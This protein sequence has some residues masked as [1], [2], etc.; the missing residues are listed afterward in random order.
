MSHDV[1]LIDAL[2]NVLW[3]YNQ[4][5]YKYMNEFIRLNKSSA[6]M[7]LFGLFPNA[8]EVTESYAALN[9]VKTKLKQYD[10]SDPEVTLVSVGDGR[11][12]RTAS[13]F[14][15][16]TNLQCISIDPLLNTEKIPYWENNIK[17]LKCYP[18]CVE[19]L[20]LCYDKVIIVAVHSHANMKNT[21]DHVRGKVR[22]MVAIPCC[23]PFVHEIKPKEFRDAGIWSP[24]NLVKVWRTI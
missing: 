12:P 5:Q 17:R 2:N 21:L 18:N 24:K 4:G 15:F 7:L 3:S 23:K 13:L 19:E 22:S 8:K 6:D 14:A 16:R 10:L 1:A 11:T 9:A 20:D